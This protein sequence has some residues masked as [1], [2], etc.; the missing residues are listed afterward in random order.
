LLDQVQHRIDEIH[1]E[2]LGHLDEAHLRR[3]VTLLS[4]VRRRT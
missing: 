3:L 2:Q 4:A 1:E